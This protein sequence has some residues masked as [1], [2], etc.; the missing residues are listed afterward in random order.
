M[1]MSVY[2]EKSIQHDLFGLF[3]GAPGGRALRERHHRTIGV[4]DVIVRFLQGPTVL[5][6]VNCES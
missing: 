3:P 4:G 2:L 1:D 5:H 6:D